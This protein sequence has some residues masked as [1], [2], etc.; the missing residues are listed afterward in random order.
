MSGIEGAIAS[1]ESIKQMGQA[2]NL[3]GVIRPNPAHASGQGDRVNL[4]VADSIVTSRARH[5]LG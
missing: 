4:G 1:R 5:C 2:L 3:Q